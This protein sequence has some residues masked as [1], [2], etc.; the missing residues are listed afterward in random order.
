MYIGKRSVYCDSSFDHV[1]GSEAKLNYSG[2]SKRRTIRLIHILVM[3][4]KIQD[5][6]SASLVLGVLSL[7]GA[8]IFVRY[9]LRIM[10]SG[11][12]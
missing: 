2:A 1:G 10:L 6:E 12:L 3:D 8:T 11:V 9:W 7:G 5:R 4:S